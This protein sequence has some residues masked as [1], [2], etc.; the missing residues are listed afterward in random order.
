VNLRN[1]P[2]IVLSLAALFELKDRS[3]G[4]V[5]FLSPHGEKDTA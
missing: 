3:N 4:A 2:Q 1:N 5:D